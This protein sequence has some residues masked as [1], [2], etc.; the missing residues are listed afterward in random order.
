MTAL[1]PLNQHP[2]DSLICTQVNSHSPPMQMLIRNGITTVIKNQF[3]NLDAEIL[4]EVPFLE[5]ASGAFTVEVISQLRFFFKFDRKRIAREVAGFQIMHSLLPQH[6]LPLLAY[7]KESGWLCLPFLASAQN[8]N[9]IIHG[10]LLDDAEIFLVYEHFLQKMF[11]LWMHTR[12]Q[13]QANASSYFQRLEN[14]FKNTIA[15]LSHLANLQCIEHLQL[16]QLPIQVNGIVYPSLN[17]L[18]AYARQLMAENP[19]PFSV[20]A[21][22][23]E[24]P[25]NILVRRQ[26]SKD[27]PDWFLIDLPNVRQDADWVWSIAKM[28]QWWQVGYYIDWMKNAAMVENRA[29]FGETV[30][31]VT[32]DRLIINY[33]YTYQIP[34]IC[35]RLDKRVE[36]LACQIGIHLHDLS[37]QSRYAASRFSILLGLIPLYVDDPNSVAILLG[38]AVQSLNQFSY[39]ATT[40]H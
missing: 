33:A 38:E 4:H 32:R 9:Q 11:T 23:D 1:L 10:S 15:S 20:T 25:K 30:Y 37:W 36:K 8:L 14:K 22:Q 2:T 5:G 29:P 21:H 19:A 34:P 17:E 6:I 35:K 18:T 3:P 7:D 12:R 31:K 40:L 39:L 13:Q 27:T 28:R 16:Q 24:H 26:G